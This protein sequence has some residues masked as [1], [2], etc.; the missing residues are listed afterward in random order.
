[1][2]PA[3]P[4]EPSTRS[5][6]TDSRNC[7]ASIDPP[8]ANV[9]VQPPL[10]TSETRS[11]YPIPTS[12]W[13]L[14]AVYPRNAS[15]SSRSWRRTYADIP[16][17]AY[18]CASSNIEALKAWNPTSVTN[19]NRYP[20]SASSSE[21]RSIV[22]WSRFR[23]QLNEGEQL[24]AR[25]LPGNASWTPSANALASPRSGREVSHHRTSANGA[26]A[27]HRAIAASSPFR[28]RKNPSTVRWPVRNGRSRGSAS[29][30]SS[31]AASASVRA[32]STVGTPRTSA[33]RRAAVSVATNWPVGTRTLPPR[34]PH[35]FSD[36]SWSSTCTPAAPASIIAFI[37][38][39]AFSGPPNPASAS[40]TTGAIHEIS[41]SPAAHAIWSARRRAFTM[42]RTSA[43]VEFEGYRLWSGYVWS[44]RFASAATCQP[45]T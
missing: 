45:E 37:S 16:S 19:W 14:T 18:A 17:R 10:T 23:L 1:A 29:F 42:R 39:N 13:C 32:T 11:K 9:E 28:T 27:R 5:P 44:A 2:D 3:A 8:S 15:S 41:S 26:Y 7:A 34:C 43:G 33:A 31:V 12:V 35:F 25:S 22:R 24:Y 38:S 21:K 4:G 40:A 20:I 30:V 36:A 6:R